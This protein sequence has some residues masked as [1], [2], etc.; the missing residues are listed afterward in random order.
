MFDARDKPKVRKH[1]ETATTPLAAFFTLFLLTVGTLLMIGCQAESTRMDPST[2]TALLLELL[3]DP[4]PDV[5]RTAALSLGKIG[6]PAGTQGLIQ[7]LS[8]SDPLVRKYS[9]WALGQIGEEVSTEAAIAL[10]SALGDEDVEV[11]HSAASALGNVGLRPPLI[12]L[13]IEGL[14]VGE[15]HSRQAVVEA[16]MQLEGRSASSVLLDTLNDPDPRV[17]QG[18]IAALG[19]LGDPTVRPAFRKLLLRDPNVGVR[20]EAA[21]RLGK[22]G[23]ETDI[24]FLQKAANRDPTPIVHLWATWAINNISPDTLPDAEPPPREKK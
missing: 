17:R 15:V 14:K 24:P 6:H 10:V 4:S 9:A 22:L 19:E 3:Q 11:K 21:Y 13:L 1:A 7:A 23:D 20:T 18:A 16:L 8:D 5:R 2:L 12:P